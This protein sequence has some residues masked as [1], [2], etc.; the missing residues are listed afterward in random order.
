MFPDIYERWGLQVCNPFGFTCML[1]L[2]PRT[3]GPKQCV[4]RIELLQNFGGTL[5]SVT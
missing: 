4:S 3:A 5:C 1:L 2:P